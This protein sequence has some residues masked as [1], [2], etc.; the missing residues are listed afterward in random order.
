MLNFD[1]SHMWSRRWANTYPAEPILFGILKRPIIPTWCGSAWHRRSNPWSSNVSITKWTT[2]SESLPQTADYKTSSWFLRI[3]YHTQIRGVSNG[4]QQ[5]RQL[6][7]HFLEPTWYR[8]NFTYRFDL[9]NWKSRARVNIS[10]SFFTFWNM[11]HGSRGY[12]RYEPTP[13]G[14]PVAPGKICRAICVVVWGSVLI[15]SSSDD[16]HQSFSQRYP[17]DSEQFAI[18]TQHRVKWKWPISV[19][20]IWF[21]LSGAKFWGS[22]KQG[23]ARVR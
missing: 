20:S 23:N 14:K 10:G 13:T 8:T 6:G 15:K 22:G 7:L 5:R 17:R 3:W 16:L 19:S 21:A 11:F 18:R 4:C 2:L 1:R 12:L 9:W